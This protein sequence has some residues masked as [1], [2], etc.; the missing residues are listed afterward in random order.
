MD[1]GQVEKALTQE[2]TITMD[3][4]GILKTEPMQYK[5][6]YL[7]VTQTAQNP[8]TLQQQKQ[9]STADLDHK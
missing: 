4:K 5:S 3:S 9:S 2:Y 7:P 8:P 6:E 1:P